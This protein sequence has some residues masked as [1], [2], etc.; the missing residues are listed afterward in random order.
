MTI[1]Y[2]YTPEIWP[3]VFTVLL[4]IALAVYSGRRR[5]VPGALPF[6]IAG[7]FAA[8]WAAGSV[9]EVAAVDLQTK[10][11]WF[12]FQGACQ[13]PAATAITCFAL[14]YAWPGRWL[15]RRNLVLLS[16]PCVLAVGI[17]L[18]NDLHHLA[19]RGFAFDGTIIPLRGPANWFFFVYGYGLAIVNIIV[20]TWLFIRSPQHRW[21]A[22][23]MIAGQFVGRLLYLLEAAKVLPSGLPFNVPPIAFEYLLYAIAL[24]GFRIFDPISLARQAVITQMHEGM[25]VVDLE[26]RVASLNPAAAAILGYPAKRLIGR[27]VQ[28]LLPAYNDLAT[29]LQKAGASQI[30]LNLGTGSEI[31]YYQLE[32]SSLK[33][34]RGLEAG[35]LLLLHDVTVQKQTQA[36][37]LEQQ[38]ALAILHEREQLAR[39]LHDST[40][41][42]LGYAGFQ[43]E[44]VH[45]RI[46]DGQEA[47]SAGRIADVHI[48]LVEA[49]SQL[50]RLSSIV[51]EAHADIREYILNLSLAPSDQRPFFATLRHYLDGFSQNYGI[52]TGLSIGPEVDEGQFDPEVQ[53]QLFRIIQEALSNARKHARASYV[54]VSFE[55]QDQPVHIRIQDNGQGFSPASMKGDGNGHFGL[56]FMRERAEQMGGNLRVESVLG[57]GTCVEVEVPCA[58]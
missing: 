37:L 34:W 28:E 17:I 20:F 13:L 22:A 6:M 36:Q 56:R 7:L 1:K 48:D 21:P 49:G 23:I 14:E 18:T 19:W 33:D 15:T 29:D 52:Q 46:V 57:E 24:F 4:L 53:M 3:S 12:K 31:R 54:Q 45:D 42:V 27:P 35:C 10:I 47:V 51:E 38:R 39:E 40:A 5:S 30:E 9:M 2:A 25:L 44:V 8:A 50:T 32:A 26:G 41:Q 55:K 43:L 16:I 11:T 58:Y